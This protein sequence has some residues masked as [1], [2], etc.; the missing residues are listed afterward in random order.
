MENNFMNLFLLVSIIFF[1]IGC[2]ETTI[3]ELRLSILHSN[4]SKSNTRLLYSQLK[5]VGYKIQLA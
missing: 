5:S 2:K 3:H 1:I 4:Y